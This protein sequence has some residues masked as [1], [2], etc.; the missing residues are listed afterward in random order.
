MAKFNFEQYRD[1]NVPKPE[2]GSPA[3]LAQRYLS[4][5]RSL[6]RKSVV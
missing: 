2:K 3:Y 5:R 4:A 1:S 6:D